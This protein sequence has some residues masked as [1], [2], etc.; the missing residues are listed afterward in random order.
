MAEITL[1]R[2]TF[3]ATLDAI[4]R[5]SPL[6]TPMLVIE[7]ASE[8]GRWILTAERVDNQITRAFGPCEGSGEEFKESF[9]VIDL[10]EEISDKIPENVQSI[11]L[12]MNNGV[13]LKTELR[14]R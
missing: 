9:N 2:K 8:P 4:Q 6:S 13:R 5:Q 7:S 3:V 12:V 14:I 1:N 10:A 11:T